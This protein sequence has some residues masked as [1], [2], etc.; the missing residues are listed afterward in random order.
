MK[1]YKLILLSMILI[2]ST[3]SA[4][5]PIDLSA[6]DRAYFL[7]QNDIRN[8]NDRRPDLIE[9]RRDAEKA[10]KND[11]NNSSSSEQG[12]TKAAIAVCSGEFAFCASSTCVRT[13][14]Q[15]TVKENGGKTTKQYPEVV[16][17]CPIITK[18][19]A[20][21]Q[22]G[23]PLVGIAALNEGN[24]AGSCAPPAAGKVWSYFSNA[25]T[26]YPQ[27]SAGFESKPAVSQSC[28]AS[29][30]G[31]SNCWSYLCSIDPKVVKTSTGD[32]RTAT[33]SC[34]LNEGL[35]GSKAHKTSSY[36]TFAGTYS[37]QP[38]GACKQAPVGY[39]NQLLQ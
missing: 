35:F 36:T 28:P 26:T 23:Q 33:C 16:C 32:V 24:M 4:A 39:P 38:S 19:I 11:S 1:L 18:K 7:A 12:A 37:S 10:K 6:P 30:G 31:G 17:T 22:N 20:V 9:Q 15:I 29:D 34:P 14:K 5:D 21:E 2:C 27:E 25:I 13:G 8:P 3:A